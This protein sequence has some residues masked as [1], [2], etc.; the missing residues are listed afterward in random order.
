MSDLVRT[1][2]A[3]MLRLRQEGPS[4]DL[5]ITNLFT[6]VLVAF[7]GWLAHEF[8]GGA[9]GRQQRQVLAYL[10]LARE[11]DEGPE[12]QEASRVAHD[13]AQELLATRG[14]V[15]RAT[16]WQTTAIVGVLLTVLYI[17]VAV[18]AS[19]TANRVI[20]IVTVVELVGLVVWALLAL[21]SIERQRRR[22]RPQP[23]VL[24]A[25]SGAGR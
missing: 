8:A 4:V 16:A 1:L 23:Q 2:R 18:V 20:A 21:R 24:T 13:R 25:R 11:L 3:S 17:P 5:V 15:G 7:A 9:E 22:Q 12:Q 6:P 14:T 19:S 10:Q